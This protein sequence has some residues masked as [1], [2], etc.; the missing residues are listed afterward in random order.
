MDVV[1]TLSLISHIANAFIVGYIL[2]SAFQT[3]TF[4]LSYP[5]LTISG[6]IIAVLLNI[7]GV[8]IVLRRKN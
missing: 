4:E 3:N 8:I 2:K 1:D 6:L 5:L 7:I